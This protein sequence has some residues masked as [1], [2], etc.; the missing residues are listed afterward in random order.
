VVSFFDGSSPTERLSQQIG[1]GLPGKAAAADATSIDVASDADGGAT[2]SSR[3]GTMGDG[4][5]KMLLE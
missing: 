5:D 2:T 3:L 1:A 4:W